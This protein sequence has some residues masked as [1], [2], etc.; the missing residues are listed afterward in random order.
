MAKKDDVSDYKKTVEP[1]L[2]PKEKELMPDAL[3]EFDDVDM[4]APS[5]ITPEEFK[6]LT[7]GAIHKDL[8][9]KK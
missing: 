4:T 7:K 9:G 3:S 6:A 8:V 5:A 2:T 1:I